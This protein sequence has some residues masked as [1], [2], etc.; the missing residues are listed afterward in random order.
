MA[1]PALLPGDRVGT[2]ADG[3]VV[4]S[5]PVGMNIGPDMSFDSYVALLSG[6]PSIGMVSSFGSVSALDPMTGLP[7]TMML[8]SAGFWN[9]PDN[10]AAAVATL[11]R[12]GVPSGLSRTAVD[13]I[14]ESNAVMSTGLKAAAI[15]AG[16]PTGAARVRPVYEQSYRIPFG[17]MMAEARMSSM[18]ARGQLARDVASLESHNAPIR[19]VNERAASI[20]KAISGRDWG[21]D[22]EKWMAWSVDLLGYVMPLRGASQP[23][24][25]VVEEVPIAFQSRAVAIPTSEVVGFRPGHSCFAKGTPVRT[26][27]G[28]RP[29]EQIEPG[30]QVLGQDVDTGAL[31]Y[32]AVLAAIHNPPARTYA[33]DLGRE[34]IHATGIHRFWKAGRGW[35]MTRD[36]QPGDRLRVVGGTAEVLSVEEEA[37]QP[38]FNLLVAGGDNFCVGESGVVAHDN[39]VASPVAIPFD[40]VPETAELLATARR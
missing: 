30:D 19:D 15:F 40:G 18:V 2:D 26:L 39:R 17:Q 5:R 10:P 8:G 35:V 9:P 7:T 21:D 6:R 16:A 23:P 14:V 12:A 32:R 20:L 37:V 34:T 28:D 11:E 29:I 4:V 38:V 3:N 1:A 24:A 25:T 13:R 27:R 22:R 31:T 36:L 33:I